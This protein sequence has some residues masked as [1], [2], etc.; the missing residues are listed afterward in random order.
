MSADTPNPPNTGKR[1]ILEL[2]RGVRLGGQLP[3]NNGVLGETA[4]FC[5]ISIDRS[6]LFDAPCSNCRSLF[7]AFPLDPLRHLA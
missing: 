7:P 2:G 1:D 4:H 3:A 6:V 5:I